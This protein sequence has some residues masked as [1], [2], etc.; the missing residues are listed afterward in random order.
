[1]SSC[2]ILSSPGK[3]LV[4]SGGMILSSLDDGRGSISGFVTFGMLNPVKVVVSM[5][6]TSLLSSN[7]GTVR[8][9]NLVVVGFLRIFLGDLGKC[10]GLIL[11]VEFS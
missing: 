7:F 3:M 6:G 10:L 4:S 9:L 5:V 8:I 1:M 2:E 11:S